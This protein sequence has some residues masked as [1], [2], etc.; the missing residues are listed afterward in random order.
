MITKQM[1]TMLFATSIEASSR[2]GFDMSSTTRRAA[3]SDLDS[4]SSISRC[5]SEKKATSEP[6][7]IAESKRSIIEIRLSTT[8][9]L[10]SILSCSSI[11]P[12]LF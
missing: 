8:I 11:T 3:E 7:A 4:S 2:S 10:S 1:L 12:I 9:V 6:E 5:V